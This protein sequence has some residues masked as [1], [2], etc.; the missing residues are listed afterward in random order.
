MLTSDFLIQS[1]DNRNNNNNHYQNIYHI[2]C[3]VSLILPRAYSFFSKRVLHLR[4]RLLPFSYMLSDIGTLS[5][6]DSVCKTHK[7]I[8]SH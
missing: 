3:R 8:L 5:F 6:K 7:I 2:I 4:Q 1:N